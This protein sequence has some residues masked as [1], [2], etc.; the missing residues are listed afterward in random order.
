M[1]GRRIR[2]IRSPEGRGSYRNSPRDSRGIPELTRFRVRAR[3]PKA[4]PFYGRACSR[5]R[6]LPG[7]Q[8]ALLFARPV[9]EERRRRRRRSPPPPPL[10]LATLPDRLL[11]RARKIAWARVSRG[12]TC[13]LSTSA[14][15]TDTH[16]T[17]GPRSQSTILTHVTVPRINTLHAHALVLLAASFLFLLFFFLLRSYLLRKRGSRRTGE[18]AS[19]CVRTRN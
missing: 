7:R 5:D 2:R 17:P 16:T 14:S 13:H 19:A 8:A 15:F 4:G 10:V 12:E 9:V 1:I 6:Q 11:H 3:R 18:R